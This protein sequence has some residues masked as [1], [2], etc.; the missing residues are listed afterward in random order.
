MA[1]TFSLL[2]KA[3]RSL[4]IGTT[5]TVWTGVGVIGTALLGMAVLGE[6]ATL[7]R[8]GGLGLIAGGI[9]L[10]KLAG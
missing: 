10:L 7:A 8:L 3:L 2:A 4:R 6:P 5:H 1:V 9:A